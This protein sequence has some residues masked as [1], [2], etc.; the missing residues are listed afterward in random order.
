MKRFMLFV[1]DDFE[2]SGGMND[3]EKSYDSFED[4][5]LDRKLPKNISKVNYFLEVFDRETLKLF[6]WN[7]K[8]WLFDRDITE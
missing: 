8:Q 6:Y 1:L 3:F 4:I 7:G 2:R 5:A